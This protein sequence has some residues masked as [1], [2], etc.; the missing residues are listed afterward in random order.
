MKY[1]SIVNKGRVLISSAFYINILLSLL[2]QVPQLFETNLILIFQSSWL[3]T[4]ALLFLTNN[5][6]SNKTLN[7]LFFLI[8]SLFVFNLI[9]EGVSHESYLDIAHLLNIFKSFF[10]LYI[11]Y[12]VAPLLSESDFLKKMGLVSL[13]GGFI[14]CVSIYL[15]AFLEQFDINSK[16][17]AYGSKNSA[18]QIILS[19]LIFVIYLFN[20]SSFKWKFVK[21]VFIAF[22]LYLMMILK[23]R[24]SLI[25]LMFF[26]LVNLKQNVN[27]K[28]VKLTLLLIIVLIV[29]LVF[30]ESLR[31]VL[32][33]SV[34]FAGRDSS[35]LN[36]ASS[37]RLDF[38]LAFP[39]LFYENILLG[40]GRYF[41]E[42]FPLS[43]LIQEGIIG[44]FFV[45]LYVLT[46]VLFFKRKLSLTT[47]F[48]ICFFLLII[49]YYFN[50]FFEEQ[51]PLGPS[52]KNFYLWLCFG[53]LLF[54]HETK[55]KPH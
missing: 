55:L 27:K 2:S 12:Q 47:P 21:Y 7:Y 16:T 24:G 4:L 52:V 19:C 9:M 23:S 20:S 17:Y 10:I 49:S 53:I 1:S 18:S 40:R 43:V 42:S 25:G 29:L 32:V 33:N 45:F 51:A 38:Y 8:V 31:D 11:S 22:A 50:G 44:G 37:G 28:L 30:N 26:V 35:D 36:E 39:D 14:L 41:S 54:K 15:Y 34:F 48:Q 6:K 46:P 5:I 3:F 13:L